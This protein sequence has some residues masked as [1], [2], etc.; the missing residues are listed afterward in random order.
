MAAGDRAGQRDYPAAARRA[1]KIFVG[2]GDCHVCHLG[3][4]FTNGEFH[5]I[6]I[7]FFTGPGRVD[8]GRHAGIEKLRASPYNLLGAHS[9]DPA[10]RGA[11]GTRHVARVHRN[12]G[13]FKVPS[14]RNAA[15]TA[16]YMHNGS[17]ATLA[18]AVRHYSE[19]DENRIHADGER[20]L[21]PL[22]LTDSEAAD[23][24]AFLESL[25]GTPAPPAPPPA[26]CLT[27]P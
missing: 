5:D 2:R 14:L 18:D 27:I 23:L 13:E 25:T 11:T 1:L 16:P 7:P 3:P 8:A 15:L 21:R 12:F 17:L 19:F 4:A 22:R 20:L 6:G 24:V 26:P 9:D 10:R